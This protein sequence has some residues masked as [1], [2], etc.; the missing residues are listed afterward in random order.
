M[1]WKFWGKSGEIPKLPKPKD[2]TSNIGRHLVV[3]L[4]L[5]PDWVWK[6]KSVSRP[7]VETPNRLEIRIFDPAAAAAANF[8]VANYNS[9]DDHPDLILFEG[10]Y[11]KNDWNMDIRSRMKM[12]S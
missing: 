5:D 9:L 1:N 11:N 4:K 12:A 8:K 7:S 6:L 2:L 10:W 3:D